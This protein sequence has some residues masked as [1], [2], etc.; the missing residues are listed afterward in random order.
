MSS[1]ALELG[2]LLHYLLDK[3]QRHM[4]PAWKA[5]TELHISLPKSTV[6]CTSSGGGDQ[7]R[8]TPASLGEDLRQPILTSG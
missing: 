1:L 4:H 2:M 3:D 6:S 5:L 7:S 8:P